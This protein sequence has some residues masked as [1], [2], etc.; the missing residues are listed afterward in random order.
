MPLNELKDH[1]EKD[2]KEF[3]VECKNC[4]RTYKRGD[5]SDKEKHDC[6]KNLKG[7]LT[8]KI[9]ELKQKTQDYE[10]LKSDSDRK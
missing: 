7:D 8:A 10:S 4:N 3:Q 2:C 5:F 1:L 6:A 9:G